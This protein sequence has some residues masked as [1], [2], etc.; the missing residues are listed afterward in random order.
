MNENDKL[1][2][3]TAE[4]K[5]KSEAMLNEVATDKKLTDTKKLNETKQPKSKLNKKKLIIVG[6]VALLILAVGA[7]FIRKA[8]GKDDDSKQAVG[9]MPSQPAG[10]TPTSGQAGFYHINKADTDSLDPVTKGKHMTYGQCD[11]QGTTTMSHAP[12]DPKDIGSIAPEGGYGG[13]HVTPIDHQ[14]YYGVDLNSKPDAYPVYATM[15][16]NLNAVGNIQGAKTSWN[17]TL[18]HSCTFMI[19]YN[20]MT[21]LAPSITKQLPANWR[22]ISG[23]VKIPVKAGD[24]IG[25]VGGQSLDFQLLNTE[26]T[27]KGLL[28]HNAYN[29][30]EPAKINGVRPLDYFSADVKATIL[31]KYLRIA[32]P[33]D[34]KYDYDVAGQAV[35]NWFKVGTNGYAGSDSNTVP[36][37]SAGHLALAYDSF[38]PT[39]LVLSIGTYQNAQPSVFVVSDKTTDWTKITPTS[40]LTK[41]ELSVGSTQTP[42]GQV[43][44]GGYVAG[45]LKYKPTTFAA[46]ALVQLT[47]K[48]HIKVELFPGKRPAEVTAFSAGAGMYDR[49]QDAHVVQ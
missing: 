3:I 10:T 5:T 32:E 9:T 25:Y 6:V 17:I 16:G 27:L 49:G 42:S 26:T 22:Q 44:G 35:G 45:G 12:M 40:G 8:I 14:Y 36:N 39:A 1:E 38:D 18:S 13:E 28:Y 46:T 34:G 30:A 2:D 29:F 43:W 37:T 15:D 23:N 11:G 47:D 19:Y 31:P 21:S 7:N 4:A 24:I 41:V 48:N 20:L 33:R